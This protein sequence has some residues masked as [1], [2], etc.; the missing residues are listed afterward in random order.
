[1]RDHS[2][3]REEFTNITVDE[4]GRWFTDKKKII[5]EK[6]LSHFKQNLFRDETGIYIYQTFHEH[7]EKGYISVHGPL[8]ALFRISDD[9]FIFESLDEQKISETEIILYG[10][11]PLLRVNRLG[12]WAHISAGVSPYF[13]ERLTEDNGTFE[14]NRSIIA[15]KKNIDWITA[16]GS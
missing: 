10:E 3:A 14:F 1:M 11:R 8:L 5:N 15:V 13:S 7:A 16:V 6:I 9:S 4:W 2:G 12:A